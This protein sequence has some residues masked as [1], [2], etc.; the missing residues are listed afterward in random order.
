MKTKLSQ[1]HYIECMEDSK[2]NGDVDRMFCSCSG[3][4]C[5]ER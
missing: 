2:E 3:R 4:A 5:G 1:A